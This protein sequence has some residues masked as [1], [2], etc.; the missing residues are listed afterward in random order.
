M[1]KRVYLVLIAIILIVSLC[2][3]IFACK[4]DDTKQEFASQKVVYAS[5]WKEVKS[6]TREKNWRDWW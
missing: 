3:T 6:S 4:K 2:L 5:T 1:K